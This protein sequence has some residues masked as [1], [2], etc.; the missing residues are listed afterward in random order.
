M[1]GVPASNCLTTGR[2]ALAVEIL[3]SALSWPVGSKATHWKA[4]RVGGSLSQCGHTCLRLPMV[5]THQVCFSRLSQAACCNLHHD[6]RRSNFHT[7]NPSTCYLSAVHSFPEI[8]MRS[9]HHAPSAAPTKSLVRFVRSVLSPRIPALLSGRCSTPASVVPAHQFPTGPRPMAQVPRS[10]WPIPMPWLIPL[11][12]AFS[13]VKD[14]ISGAGFQRRLSTTT[15][16]NPRL[17]AGHPHMS[18]NPLSLLLHPVKA[19]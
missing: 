16:T 2:K 3:N 8:S 11:Y 18:F 7:A 5:Q 15:Q 6:I 17:C 12:A 9:I 1:D 10:H 13:A 14:I 19:H 4:R